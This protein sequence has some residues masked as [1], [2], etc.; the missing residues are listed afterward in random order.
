MNLQA[1]AHRLETPD[2][3]ADAGMRSVTLAADRVVI[4]RSVGGVRMRIGL[5]ARAYRGVLLSI[6]GMDDEGFR[7][8]VTLAHADGDLCVPLSQ[9]YDEAEAYCAWR[10]WGRRLAAPL[11]VERIPGEWDVVEAPRAPALAPAPRRRGRATLRRRPRFLTRRKM[12]RI[13]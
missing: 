7:Y 5:R 11:L 2:A 6:A 10:L 8:E 12:G 1:E 4:S 3:R 13:A 9:T